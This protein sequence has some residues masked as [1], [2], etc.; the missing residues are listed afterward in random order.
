MFVCFLK[1]RCKRERLKVILPMFWLIKKYG[2]VPERLPDLEAKV[3][4]S[5]FLLMKTETW[6]ENDMGGIEENFSSRQGLQYYI[7]MQQGGLDY[8]CPFSKYIC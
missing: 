1:N 6:E 7:T 4:F 8:A 3:M 5:P 2:S